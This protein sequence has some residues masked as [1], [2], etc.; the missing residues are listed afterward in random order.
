MNAATTAD[1]ARLPILLTELRLPT[2]KRMWETIGAQSDREGWKAARL[3]STLLD[4]EMAER[5]QRRL[6]RYRDDSQ[7]PADKR[8]DTFD[9]AP[10]PMLSKAHVLACGRRCLDRKRSQP[11]DVRS[12]RRR[13]IPP[14]LRARSCANR[15]WLARA[16]YQHQRTG[17]ATA[18][19]T[20]RSASASRAG[21]AR[22]VRSLDL[23]RSQLRST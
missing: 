7:L 22:S 8:L 19:S 16:V 23:G 18:S 11:V 9:F 13:K 4:L 1:A 3:L 2:L 15:P 5:A 10:L 21:K 12:A 20:A 17:S 14:G 6:A